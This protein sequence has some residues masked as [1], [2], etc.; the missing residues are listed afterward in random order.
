M[1][2]FV[3]STIRPLCEN[4]KTPPPC[5]DPRLVCVVLVLCDFPALDDSHP[6][7]RL[8]PLLDV[9]VGESGERVPVDVLIGWPA[10]KEA[11]GAIQSQRGR[12]RLPVPHGGCATI[13]HTA[14]L[15][16]GSIC[17]SF[18][19]LD[20]NGASIDTADLPDATAL[21]SSAYSDDPS[22]PVGRP[23]RWS[24]TWTHSDAA[25]RLAIRCLVP[26]STRRRRSMASFWLAVPLCCA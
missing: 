23:T 20:C 14:A 21:R 5:T 7:A 6:H 18:P 12:G 10:L 24:S 26:L 19:N 25:S 13:Y 16:M 2:I 17:R 1:T 9:T 8:L 15:L 4:A 11:A 22:P 3:S